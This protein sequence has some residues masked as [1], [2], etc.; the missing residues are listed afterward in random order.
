MSNIDDATR[1]ICM[2]EKE[3]DQFNDAGKNKGPVKIFKHLPGI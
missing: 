1:S 3:V 2:I